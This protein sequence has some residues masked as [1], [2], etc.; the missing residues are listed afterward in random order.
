M[1]GCSGALEQPG[2]DQGL[3]SAA[4][5]M[6]LAMGASSLAGAANGTTLGSRRGPAPPHAA[7]L[8]PLAGRLPLW[9][10]GVVPA[11]AIRGLE[12]KRRRGR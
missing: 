4:G 6:A 12:V 10:N 5:R 1:R 9:I 3:S 7:V 2:S 8:S 11:T